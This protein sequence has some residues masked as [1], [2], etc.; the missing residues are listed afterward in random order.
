MRQSR[1]F[2]FYL[3]NALLL[4]SCVFADSEICAVGL[5][6][7]TT[8]EVTVLSLCTAGHLALGTYVDSGFTNAFSRV[9]VKLDSQLEIVKYLYLIVTTTTIPTKI[10]YISTNLPMSNTA[11]GTYDV[12][13]TVSSQNQT[14]DSIVGAQ[15]HAKCTSTSA[16][17]GIEVQNQNITSLV[18]VTKC[19]CDYNYELRAGS[20]QLCGDT[21]FKNTISNSSCRNCPNNKVFTDIKTCTC[22]PGSSG[23]MGEICVPCLAGFYN[24]DGGSVTCSACPLHTSSRVESNTITNCT[25]NRGYSGQD[26]GP[27]KYVQRASTKIRREIICALIVPRVSIQTKLVLRHRILVAIVQVNQPRLQ[28]ATISQRARALRVGMACSA[29][30]VRNVEATRLAVFLEARR[31]HNVHLGEALR[32]EAIVSTLASV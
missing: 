6:K 10:W 8:W 29:R 18:Q 11:S 24:T 19:K 15:A 20:C 25:C 14:I 7:D 16:G 2:L 22:L 21:R 27:C 9:Y 1:R 12:R 28:E 31:A 30:T 23:L 26:A 32:W 13:F 5:A 17:S 4:L 3:S